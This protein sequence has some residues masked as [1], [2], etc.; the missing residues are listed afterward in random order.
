MG[1]DVGHMAAARKY[2]K[3][4]L[5]QLGH[6]AG[7]VQRDGVGFALQQNGWYPEPS[8]LRPEIVVAQTGPDLLLG[9]SGYPERR[10]VVGSGRIEEVGSHGKLEGALSISCG[11]ALAQAAG[12]QLGS[13]LLQ[14]RVQIPLLK[15]SL[16]ILPGFTPTGRGRDQAQPADS[17]GYWVE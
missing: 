4:R 7:S 17:T 6:R 3:L 16:E 13:L 12:S 11:V 9:A 1:L 15:P 10:Q 14:S 5:K 2:R 8:K